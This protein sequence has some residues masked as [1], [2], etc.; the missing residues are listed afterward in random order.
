MEK[1]N[2]QKRILLIVEK[3]VEKT[4]E[5]MSNKSLAFELQTQ[6]S[7]ICRDLKILESVGW[8]EKSKTNGKWKIS[9]KF[10]GLSGRIMKGFQ[11]AR[12]KLTENEAQ[13]AS[14]M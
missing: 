1:L 8:I 9:P 13:Y 2:S 10:G 6:E 12:L 4:V 3:L 7:N 5:G 14:K 11:S